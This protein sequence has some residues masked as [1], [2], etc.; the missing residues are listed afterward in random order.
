MWSSLG[1]LA[2]STIV[3]LHCDVCEG[4]KAAYSWS[5]L[6]LVSSLLQNTLDI[7]NLTS[8]LFEVCFWPNN[9]ICNDKT[10]SE[11]KPPL[12]SKQLKRI[13]HTH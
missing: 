13:I 5:V 7:V 12:T 2:K 6:S 8:N 1:L 3:S 4:L 11:I 9:L 10:L